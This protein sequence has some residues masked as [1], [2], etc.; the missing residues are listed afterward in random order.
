MKAPTKPLI[1]VTWVDPTH[2]AKAY[3]DGKAELTRWVSTGYIIDEKLSRG[4]PTLVI[5]Q[6]WNTV[7]GYSDFLLVPVAL[8]QVREVWPS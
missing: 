2:H 3:T 8:V 7:D 4:V 5:A 6:S 1:R